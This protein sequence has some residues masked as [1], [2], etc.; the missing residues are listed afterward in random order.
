MLRAVPELVAPSTS[1]PGPARK[2]NLLVVPRG[3]SL[4]PLCVKCGQ[5]ASSAVLKKKYYWH[6]P[7]LFLLILI[8]VLIYAIVAIIVRKSFELAVPLCEEHWQRRRRALWTGGGLL[9]G[10]IVAP[11]FLTGF[12]RD[13]YGGWWALFLF[14]AGVTGIV[15]L[16]LAPPLAPNYI[17]DREARFKGAGEAF[18]SQL[19]QVQA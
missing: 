4:P 1:P 14:A 9:V 2:D 15:Y 8:G 7:W 13:G 11:I 6:T 12:V 3:V 5:P 17:D 10:S 19:P 18:L 16:A